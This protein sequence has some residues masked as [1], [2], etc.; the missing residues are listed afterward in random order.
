MEE[1]RKIIKGSTEHSGISER[2]FLDPLEECIITPMGAND[3][4]FERYGDLG[5]D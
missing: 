3:D 4:Y 1:C 5:S 2:N